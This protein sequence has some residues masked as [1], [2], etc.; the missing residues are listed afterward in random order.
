[1]SHYNNGIYKMATI[2]NYNLLIE[3]IN[4]NMRPKD[5]E[6]K[7]LGEVFTPLWLVDEMLNKLNETY[8]K[9]I[10]NSIFS[11]P[12]L[13]WLDPAV[14]IGNFMI[15]LYYR[16]MKELI[17]IT[18]VGERQKHILENML[19]MC[20]INVDSVVMLNK[21]F[22]GDKYKLNINLGDTLT[23]TI[24][25]LFDVVIGNPP[26]QTKKPNTVKS[27]PLWNKFVMKSLTILNENGYLVLIHPSGWRNVDGIYKKVQNEILN[28]NLEYLEIHNENDGMKTFNCCTRY[29]WYVLK[30]EKVD[31]TNTVIKFQ[32]E[33]LNV[34]V[35]GL[36]F[37]P[38]GAF[39]KIMSLINN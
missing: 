18:D 37:I 11:N 32:D 30:N 39:T 29:D 4:R 22:C 36:Q 34:N 5:K 8:T 12:D 16:L 2:E 26:F 33:V 31:I 13:K 27:Q 7:E 6:K 10:G 3:F 14:G 24:N 25:E 35:I 17:C 21:I 28:R 9:S 38:N 15:V 1:M 20:E 19:Y 23:M